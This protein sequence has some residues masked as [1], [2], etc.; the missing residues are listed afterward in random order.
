MKGVLVLRV[1]VCDISDETVACFD[2]SQ[3]QSPLLGR[4][5]FYTH[6]PLC[7]FLLLREMSRRGTL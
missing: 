2:G 4:F 5:L 6:L 3:E 1:G 7:D